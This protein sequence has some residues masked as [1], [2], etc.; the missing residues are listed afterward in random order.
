MG[1][2]HLAGQGN[3]IVL[4][5]SCQLLHCIKHF[6]ILIKQKSQCLK[7][8]LQ[9]INIDASNLL[10]GKQYLSDLRIHPATLKIRLLVISKLLT[11]FSN[12]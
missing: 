4:L 1:R 5:P 10:L 3:Q 7:S 9:L 8:L 11:I 2:L 12:S 6:Q